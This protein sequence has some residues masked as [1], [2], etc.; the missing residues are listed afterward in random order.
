ILRLGAT[1]AVMLGGTTALSPQ[2]QTDL[3][4][5]GLSVRRLAGADRYE[6]AAAAAA[7]TAIGPTGVALVASGET[8]PDALAAGALGLPVLLTHPDSLP[9][10]TRAAIGSARPVVVGGPFAVNNGVVPGAERVGGAD[11]YAT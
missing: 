3:N 10:A 5:L 11:R 9:D 1:K 7:A 2:V 6:T 4:T 8:F